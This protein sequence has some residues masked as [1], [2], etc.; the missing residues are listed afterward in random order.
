MFDTPV[1]GHNVK[2]A[3][4]LSGRACGRWLTPPHIAHQGLRLQYINISTKTP[5]YQ[6]IDAPRPL[7][8]KRHAPRLQYPRLQYINISNKTPICQYIDQDCNISQ[9]FL[10]THIYRP[11]N[12]I[13]HAPRPLNVILHAPRPLNVIPHAPRPQNI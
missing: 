9:Y 10:I 2:S 13:L 11:L 12:V 8:V 1:L 5:I 6:Y 7:N 3:D 4:P